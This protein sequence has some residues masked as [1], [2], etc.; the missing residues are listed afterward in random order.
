MHPNA[1]EAQ[2]GWIYEFEDD[3]FGPCR[4]RSDHI[5][6]T[7]HAKPHEMARDMMRGRP[8]SPL[9][10]ET[11]HRWLIEIVRGPRSGVIG[12]I[13]ENPN[14]TFRTILRQPLRSPP[15]PTRGVEQAGREAV[16]RMAQQVAMAEHPEQRP[17]G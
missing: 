12:E 8:V 10:R 11:E 9:T 16:A 1:P 13:V 14:G 2:H 15:M 7:R 3:T 17:G 6:R 5:G 4:I